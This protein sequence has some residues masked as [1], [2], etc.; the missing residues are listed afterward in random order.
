[1]TEYERLVSLAQDLFFPYWNERAKAVQEAGGR[2]AYYTTAEV[3]TEIILRQQ[4][5]LRNAS[6]MNDFSEI[7]H[8]MKC[9]RAAYNGK[10]GEI[11]RRALS[12]YQGLPTEVQALFDDLAS[13][14]W[15][16]S[17]IGCVS[18]HLRYPRSSRRVEGH[19][20]RPRMPRRGAGVARGPSKTVDNP[21]GT[22]SLAKTAVR[23]PAPG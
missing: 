9:L 14:I 13:A 17:Y 2:F 18:E 3:A 21:W 15:L 22:G 5:W 12:A 20:G 10:G 19:I 4:I 1:V 16:D 8:G 23:L 6:L 7:T 11:L